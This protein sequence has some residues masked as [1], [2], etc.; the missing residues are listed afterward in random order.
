MTL[1]PVVPPLAAF[2]LVLAVWVAV[3]V[4]FRRRRVEVRDDGLIVDRTFAFGWRDI[5]R[6][7]FWIER[8]VARFV[9]HLGASRYAF[10]HPEATVSDPLKLKHL[11]IEK[12]KLV[13][14]PPAAPRVETF[15]RHGDTGRLPRGLLGDLPRPT[16]PHVIG[17]ALAAIVLWVTQAKWIA[18]AISLA[19]SAGAYRYLF[20]S[21]SFSVGLLVVLL[22]HE[23][24][25]AWVARA[26]GLRAGA[27]I[28]IPLLGAFIALRGQPRD[29]LVESEIAYGGPLA[30][31][32]ASTVAFAASYVSGSHLWLDV[33]C[34]GFAF[35]LFNMIPV[36][37]LDGARITSAITPRLWLFGVAF[38][39]GTFALTWHRSEYAAANVMFLIIASVGVSN[40]LHAWF[41]PS[42]LGPA[43]YYSVPGPYR[44]AMGAAYFG[45]SVF[46]GWMTYT[47]FRLGAF[48]QL[49]G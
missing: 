9:V 17:T 22:I 34:A 8:G 48:P 6:L 43:S 26:H 31:A 36:H 1:H 35:N 4:L 13:K 37:P 3:R 45:L 20:S 28:F 33:A 32:L 30:G 12:S 16:R 5:R 42:R 18:T 41:Q 49:R 25:H 40:A 21:W 14:D 19:V 39:I 27:P 10:A 7:D 23:L 2:T 46:L 29:A 47:C 11:I 38:L 44:F 15:V 24:G